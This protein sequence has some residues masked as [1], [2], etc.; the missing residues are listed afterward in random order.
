MTKDRHSFAGWN[1]EADGSGKNYNAYDAYTI[2][3]TA[4]LF[5][6]WTRNP[7]TLIV[8]VS[9]QNGGTVLRAPNK[10]TYV[11]GEQVMLTA[12]PANG[13]VF[14]GWSGASSSANATVTVAMDD[15]KTLTAGFGLPDAKQFTVYFNGNGMT[16]GNNPASAPIDSGSSITLP[17]QQTMVKEGHTFGGW[18]TN[19]AGT[20]TN[21]GENAS[22]AVTGN[23]T[24]YAKW[25]AYPTYTVTYNG[26]G[27]TANVPAAVS[28]DSGST[29]TLSGQGSMTRTG[30][31][32]GGWNT[33]N[34]GTGT[35]YAT[36]SS[37]KVTGSVTLYAKWTAYPTYTVTYNGNGTTANVPT[38]VTADSGSSVTLSSMT[39]TGYNFGG[40]NT[41]SAGTGTNYAAGAS[42]SVTGNVTLYAR[43][44]TYPTYTV[45]YNG[46]GTTANVPTAV[47]ADS[48]SSVTLSS[49][50]RSGY[51]FG[52]WNTNSG[53][54]G[55]NYAAGSSYKVTGNV[56]LYAKW[57][58][59][60]TYTI[61]YNGNGTTANVPTA[62][63]TDSGSTITLSSMTRTGYN[64]G[65]WNTNSAGTG[66]NYAAGSSYKVT[67]NVTLY[68]KWT[69]Y[70]TYTVTYNGNGTTAN[71]PASVSTDSGSTITL[72]NQGSMTR[73]GDNFGG[74]NTNSG[75][76]GTSYAAGASYKVTG[77]VTLYA[78]WTTYPTYTVTYN[79]NG[80]TANVPTAVTADS[81][82]SVT[83]SSMTRA[84]YNFGGWNTSNAGTG[85]NYAA[86][87]YYSIT[88]NVTLYAKWTIKTFTVTYNGNGTTT[89]VPSAVTAD[90]GSTI[91][92]SSMTRTGYNFG[93]WN[94]NSAGTGTN[95]AAG[96]S[97]SV[98]GSVTLYAKW[99]AYP[100]YTVTYNGNGTT[101]NVPA[102]VT[103][104]SGSTITLSGQGS[105][106][107]AGYNFGGWNTN[108]AGTGT[109]YAA[110]TSYKVT[111]SVTLY[112]KWTAYPTYTV[113]YNG[114]GTTA[115]VP[116]AVSTDSGSTI[117]LSGQGSMTRAG[118][119][120]GGW[121]TS[122]AGTGTNYA[123]GSSY[124]VTGN[125]TLY[126]K[127]T[128][129]TF[130]VTYNGNGTTA[131]VP[132][133]VSTDSGSTIT[134]SGQGSMTRSGYNFGGWNTNSGGTGTNYAAGS[135]YSV[136][137]NVTIY[138]KWTI[139]TYMITFDA[140][141]GTVTPA[142]GTT[143][144]G[145]KLSSLPTPTRSCYTFGGWYT[146]TTGGTQ[147]T[148]STVFNANA[149]IYA[150]WTAL[151]YTLT[152]NVSSAGGGT[153]SRNPSQINY[154]CGTS[155]TVTATPA[156]GYVFT[157]WTGAVS[158]KTNPVTVTVNSDLT[159]TASFH[160][161]FTDT[162][163]NKTYKQVTI[164]NQTWMAE[165]L[166]YD[167]ADG[168]GSWCYNNSSDSCNKY[169]RLYNWDTAMGGSTSSTANPSGVQGV[170][171]VGWHLPSRE[172]W[173]ELVTFAGGL[174]TVGKKLK[175]MSG[176]TN[177][178]TDDYGFSA[179]PSGIRSR[180]GS[181]DSAG[182]GCVWWAATHYNGSAAYYGELSSD[183]FEYR[184]SD[185]K[186]YGFSVRCV[187][188]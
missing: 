137:G 118:Y 143:G 119:N 72:P 13:N 65:G 27:T 186:D 130:T 97:Y 141:G 28:A 160:V 70:P 167:T 125:V 18:N 41:N 66:T 64:F 170:C 57:T 6:R 5:A 90:S 129:K 187:G 15:D 16:G 126:A 113:T 36:G 14:K 131:N 158:G 161:V 1:T 40:W 169:G 52:G 180:G 124:S 179:L 22:Y 128:I 146:A 117:T 23:V 121:N 120:F 108:S 45:T 134:L 82:S 149:T 164:G 33:S 153:V 133:A 168:T 135:S 114:N 178:G 148:E 185:M 105:M 110:G 155:V 42:Y 86:G 75:G 9:P 144:D 142:S 78:R 109:N 54:T 115:N 174:S 58:A 157:G 4:T 73:T 62:V 80:T 140:N 132:A 30:Y 25:T 88:G 188:D 183:R 55:T 67:G 152:A 59:Y 77:S 24:L 136:T 165:N 107:R 111:G 17:G 166:N 103:A 34:A 56:T 85:T 26:N 123:A 145:W 173:G 100:T 11:H 182:K 139:S 39:R 177:N 93:G 49:M 104:D 138:A 112:A 96:I 106:T 76:T 101:A 95:Y 20:G 89:G 176:W 87:S 32:F 38:T 175:S 156:S 51:N 47:S 68:A 3:R 61:T 99:T 31:N 163:N 19:A 79:G 122:S 184:Y 43:W 10:D 71:V 172:E 2:T 7:Y 12:T 91:T 69:A 162:R 21:Y 94:T 35:N 8:N 127:W 83:L 53:G 159:L 92:L 60:P 29:I 98:T 116:A 74:W 150:Q 63:S 151:S 50:T 102:A 84:G 147:V 37:Y 46:N 44:T 81:G 154:T 48:G 181:F 171:P